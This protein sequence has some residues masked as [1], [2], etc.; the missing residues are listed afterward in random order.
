LHVWVAPTHVWVGERKRSCCG[1]AAQRCWCVESNH[2]CGLAV[3]SMHL[4]MQSCLA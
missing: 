3:K 1:R 4:D 2:G